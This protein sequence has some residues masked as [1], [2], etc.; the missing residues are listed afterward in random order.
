MANEF[1]W[2]DLK[3]TGVRSRNVF[4]FLVGF[5]SETLFGVYNICSVPLVFP[6]KEDLSGQW[7]T[8]KRLWE[9]RKSVYANGA[10]GM[11]VNFNRIAPWKYIIYIYSIRAL[12]TNLWV[13]EIYA[14]MVE[15]PSRITMYSIYISTLLSFRSFLVYIYNE[16]CWIVELDL[17]FMDWPGLG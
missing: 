15:M 11:D 16:L 9:Q 7:N 3:T 8:W 12:K 2:F 13:Q 6:A 14:N 17:E 4:F 10:A 5:C 1:S